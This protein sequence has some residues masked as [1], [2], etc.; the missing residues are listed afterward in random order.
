MKF[1]HIKL[2]KINADEYE[3]K[4]FQGVSSLPNP[5]VRLSRHNIILFS[6]RN[7]GDERTHSHRL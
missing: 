5:F 2:E 7:H 1:V 4:N 6:R 3:E